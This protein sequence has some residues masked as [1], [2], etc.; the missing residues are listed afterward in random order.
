MRIVK[1]N[2]FKN[3]G[4]LHKEWTEAGVKASRVTTHRHVKEFGYG[5][6]IVVF[7]F[8]RH[9]RTTDNVRGVLPGLRRRRTGLFLLDEKIFHLKAISL[10]SV[11]LRFSILKTFLNCDLCSQR[12]MQKC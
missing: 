12:Q 7:L 4:E 11:K 8:L 9:S 2:L 6:S 5:C 10:A 1:E 3:L